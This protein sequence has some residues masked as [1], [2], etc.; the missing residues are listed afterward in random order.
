MSAFSR[1]PENAK[2]KKSFIDSKEPMARKFVKMPIPGLPVKNNNCLFY[3]EE[4]FYEE[5]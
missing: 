3:S 5:P 4:M 2:S 1:L